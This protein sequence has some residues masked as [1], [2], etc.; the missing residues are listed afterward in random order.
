MS[1]KDI[2]EV[3]AAES[4]ACLRYQDR[5]WA[6]GWTIRAQWSEWDVPFFDSAADVRRFLTASLVALDEW[7]ARRG[8]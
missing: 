1:S 2:D 4:D 5:Q 3:I 8:Q 6:K 7:E